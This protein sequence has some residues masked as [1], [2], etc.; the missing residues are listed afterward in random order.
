[1]RVFCCVMCCNRFCLTYMSN[2]RSAFDDHQTF[3]FFSLNMQWKTIADDANEEMGTKKE[4]FLLLWYWNDSFV[5][6]LW[7][8]K[9]KIY[10]DDIIIST[11]QQRVKYSWKPKRRRRRRHLNYRM[12][13]ERGMTHLFFRFENLKLKRLTRLRVQLRWPHKLIILP[14]I[15]SDAVDNNEHVKEIRW[16]W[17]CIDAFLI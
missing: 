3:L 1:M 15:R 16:C 7:Q 11:S 17:I 6:H 9:K 5:I 2:V 12:I 10:V 14:Y 4:T 13:C 8:K